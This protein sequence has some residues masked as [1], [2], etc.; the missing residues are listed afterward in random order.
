VSNKP[1]PPATDDGAIVVGVDDFDSDGTKAY[2]LP[3][4]PRRPATPTPPVATI[5]TAVVPGCEVEPDRT[6]AP[7]LPPPPPIPLRSRTIAESFQDMLRQA[8]EAGRA[9]S[10]TGE[11]FEIWYQREVLS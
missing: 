11:T 1:R 7:E 3:N 6:S 4:E 9:S 10:Q 5:P 2:Y 8:F